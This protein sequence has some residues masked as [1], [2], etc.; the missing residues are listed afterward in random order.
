LGEASVAVR[1]APA[2]RVHD[3][4]LAF[5]FVLDPAARPGTYALPIHVTVASL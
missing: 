5:R 4:E 3:F 1:Q 2:T